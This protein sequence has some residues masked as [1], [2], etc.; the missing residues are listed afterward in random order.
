MTLNHS[1]EI[2]L[3]PNYFEFLPLVEEKIF[4]VF[5]IAISHTPWRQCFFTQ[6]ISVKLFL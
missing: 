6:Q 3:S 1:H 2:S 4:K 5:V